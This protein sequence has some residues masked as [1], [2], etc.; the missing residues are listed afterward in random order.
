MI[1]KCYTPEIINVV[2]LIS[3]I[4]DD[5]RAEYDPTN[6]K[7]PFYEHG[8]PLEIVN[9]LRKRTSSP[10]KKFEKFP[11]IALFEDI[12]TTNGEGLF[13]LNSKLN[14]IIAVN[15]DRDYN[16]EKRYTE[17]FD[18]VLTPLYNLFIKHY[19]RSRNVHSNHRKVAHEP[20]YRLNWGKKGL[21]G[22]DGNIFNDYI[23]AIE[24]K[25]LDAKIYR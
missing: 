8:H 12:D 13:R 24:I 11:L 6:D 2:N 9:T 16:A 21:Y 20:I 17:S 15:T 25:N 22:T 14:L 18:K 10:T 3:D 1:E 23:D 19:L 5:V 7:E 4:V